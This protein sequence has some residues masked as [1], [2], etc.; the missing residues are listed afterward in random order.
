MS[1]Y[2]DH[3]SVDCA[4]CYYLNT[5]TYTDGRNYEVCKNYGYILHPWKG[6]SEEH[7]KGF[8]NPT[9]GMELA[10]ARKKAA[11]LKKRKR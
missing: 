5:G 8:T 10:E 4:G 1:R 9:R 6:V 3:K 2:Y 11:E 7:C